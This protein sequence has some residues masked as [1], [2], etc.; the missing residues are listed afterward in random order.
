MAKKKTVEEEI[1]NSP[2]QMFDRYLEL[3]FTNDELWYRFQGY[4][5]SS[6]PYRGEEYFE[7]RRDP[8]CIEIWRQM[9]DNMGGGFPITLFA[10][11]AFLLQSY[12]D[13]GH[14]LDKELRYA[15]AKLTRQKKR[16]ELRE[17]FLQ[18][19]EPIVLESAEMKLKNPRHL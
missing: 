7:Y 3:I 19:S 8:E 14:D 11:A 17:N 12:R 4:V 15:K 13:A 2:I 10:S 1:L 16:N 18:N 6:V 5:R 9:L